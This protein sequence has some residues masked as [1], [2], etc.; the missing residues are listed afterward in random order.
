MYE[1]VISEAVYKIVKD[2]KTGAN[3]GERLGLILDNVKDHVKLNA[4]AFMIFLDILRD[5]D[6][7]KT[8]LIKSCQNIKVQYVNFNPFFSNTLSVSELAAT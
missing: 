6:L 4:N 1:E 5:D 3:G 2:K 8:L 7:F